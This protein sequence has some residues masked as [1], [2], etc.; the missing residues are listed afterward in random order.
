MRRNSLAV[1]G[2]PCACA[3]DLSPTMNDHFVSHVE[4]LVPSRGMHPS[5]PHAFRGGR[6]RMGTLFRSFCIATRDP[7]NSLIGFQEHF[8]SELVLEV[9][10]HN[11]RIRIGQFDSLIPKSL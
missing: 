7:M 5:V 8:L 1:L 4:F 11:E 2:A 10:G 3:V 6:W 9:C